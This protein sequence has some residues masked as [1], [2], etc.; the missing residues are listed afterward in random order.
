MIIE[1]IKFFFERL[2]PDVQSPGAAVESDAVLLIMQ[3]RKFLLET[4]NH[5]ALRQTTG[6]E[7]G[8]DIFF[9]DVAHIRP[10]DSNFLHRVISQ[11]VFPIKINRSTNALTQSDFRRPTKNLLTRDLR[12]F[13]F[14]TFGLAQ[15]M[16]ESTL[17]S[18][19]VRNR[20]I[21]FVDGV[22]IAEPNVHHVRQPIKMLDAVPYAISQVARIHELTSSRTV[23]PYLNLI[24]TV[25]NRLINLMDRRREQMRVLAGEFVPTPVK[26]AWNQSFI[27]TIGV[28]SID[29]TAHS[30]A[31][32][33]R[34]SIT[35]I[36]RLKLARQQH[37]FHQRFIHV[38]RIHARTAYV[39][40]FLHAR[41]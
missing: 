29:I 17:E 18:D 24:S 14:H 26:I 9:A 33:F 27:M 16:N 40:K 32:N 21:I 2:E 34:Q 13:L 28:L 23:A 1:P 19:H 37:V 39:D 38:A 25:G 8:V 12:Q 6:V 15:I 20:L 5:I 31:N 36:G 30:G 11:N 10:A 41:Q 7:R 3:S 22:I 4:M 35:F